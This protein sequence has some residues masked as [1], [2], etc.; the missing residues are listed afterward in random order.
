M[1]KQIE[2]ISKFRKAAVE[3][4]LS[5][6]AKS[7]HSNYRSK[8]VAVITF[9]NV[10]MI[11]EE[12]IL[13]ALARQIEVM[14]NGRFTCLTFSISRAEDLLEVSSDI[15]RMTV[16][17]RAGFRAILTIPESLWQSLV[18]I[19]SFSLWERYAYMLSEI[20]DDPQIFLTTLANTDSVPVYKERRLPELTFAAAVAELHS[21]FTQDELDYLLRDIRTTCSENETHV[22]IAWTK[23]ELL[24]PLT[25]LYMTQ[26]ALIGPA[27]KFAEEDASFYLVWCFKRFAA[28]NQAEWFV[29]CCEQSSSQEGEIVRVLHSLSKYSMKRKSWNKAMSFLVLLGLSFLLAESNEPTQ[30][31]GVNLSNIDD[32]GAMR[33]VLAILE[34]IGVDSQMVFANEW[35]QL[36]KNILPWVWVFASLTDSLDLGPISENMRGLVQKFQESLNKY[37]SNQLA[38]LLI[39]T[40]KHCSMVGGTSILSGQEFPE[41]LAKLYAILMRGT[42]SALGMRKKFTKLPLSQ[43]QSNLRPLVSMRPEF[44]DVSRALN[45]SIVAGEVKLQMNKL[46]ASDDPIDEFFENYAKQL[47]ENDL[48][49]DARQS[50]DTCVA[51]VETYLKLNKDLAERIK[52]GS[53]LQSSSHNLIRNLQFESHYDRVYILVIDGFSYLE[54][55]LGKQRF[56]NELHGLVD[57]LED[58]SFAALPTYTPCALT[59]LLTGFTPAE[60]GVWDWLVMLDHGSLMNLT[61]VSEA[62]CRNNISVFTKPRIALSLVHNH[63][64]SGLSSVHRMLG[65]FDMYDLSS[66]QQAKAITMAKDEVYRN[67]FKTKLVAFYISDFDKFAHEHL[68]TDG[69]QQY[70][71]M[72][73]ERII[74][75]LILPIIRKAEETKSRVL[76][77]LTADHGKLTRYENKM[78]SRL[79]SGSGS[80]YECA[81]FLEP[82]VWRKS[83]RH[84]IGYIPESDFIKVTSELQNRFKNREDLLILFGE[85]VGHPNVFD[86]GTSLINPNFL[87]CSTH[88]LEGQP[89]AHGG[90]TIS[91]M[92]VPA[93]KFN[94]G[95]H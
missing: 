7:L 91:E 49:L 23:K 36:G 50:K 41:Q 32:P 45:E 21:P 80:L 85:E 40:V 12:P 62:Q 93:I 76:V 27:G 13:E 37:N 39:K 16:E 25:S 4:G 31:M 26:L 78:L 60:S 22:Y 70:Y 38:S 11:H 74:H 19:P 95:D 17:K 18:N 55:K 5:V 52:N 73:V 72:Q 15:A 65:D 54:W 44:R 86:R 66:T 20:D 24:G 34:T 69:W 64:S 47:I 59:A 35:K 79:I 28:L 90:A 3:R 6:T 75:S 9:R 71:S 30:Y 58:Y 43:L 84:L 48:F 87:V 92:V 53:L 1:F 46:L 14:D 8:R 68:Y 57:I 33:E 61:E 10:P 82:Y 2:A 81:N 94:Y 56:F 51:L 89:I 77:I 42:I 29:T 67:P 63:G 83:L 88:G